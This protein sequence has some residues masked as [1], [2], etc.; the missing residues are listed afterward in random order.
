V[1]KTVRPIAAAR[2]GRV[3]AVFG[4]GGDRDKSKRPEMGRIAATLADVVVVTSD[5]P[6]S[7]DPEAIL[8]D[9]RAGVEAEGKSARYVVDRRQ[10][11]AEAIALARAGDV[12][13]VAG[14]GHETY[15]VV[16]GRRLP[17]DDRVVAKELLEE[18]A[19]AA[20]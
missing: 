8:K 20:R 18:R 16:G 11:L 19:G 6:R 12:V 10:A 14:K 7:E 3:I 15:Q 4:C 2:G 5:N 13:L 9:V 1:L 17:F